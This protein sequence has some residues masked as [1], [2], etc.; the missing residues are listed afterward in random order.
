MFAA[1]YFRGVVTRR[2]KGP[3]LLREE[4]AIFLHTGISGRAV[5][6]PAVVTTIAQEVE[7]GQDM[8]PVAVTW[9]SRSKC[10]MGDRTS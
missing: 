7:R 3:C 10:T 5:M 1:W 2:R 6:G 4:A 9:T 8:K